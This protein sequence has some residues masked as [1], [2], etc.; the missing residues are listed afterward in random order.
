M[1]P[2]PRQTPLLS[3]RHLLPQTFTIWRDAP[4]KE[5]YKDLIFLYC[6]AYKKGYMVR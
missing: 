1:N 5:R 3:F 4:I 6:V 2:L